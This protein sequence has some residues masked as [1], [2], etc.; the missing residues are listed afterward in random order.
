MDKLLTVAEVATIL[1]VTPWQVRSWS[2]D[3]KLPAKR[4]GKSW[5]FDPV[6][7]KRWVDEGKAGKGGA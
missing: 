6:E 1:R 5:L 2:R 3:G 7:L 4:V